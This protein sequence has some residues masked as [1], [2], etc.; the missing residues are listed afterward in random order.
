[1]ASRPPKPPDA[2]LSYTRWD[3]GRDR[4]KIS[5]FR[6]ELAAAVR[7]VTGK[8]FEIFQDVDDID[9]SERWSDKLDQMLDEARFFIPILTPSYFTSKRCREELEKFLRAEADRGR[10]D[11]VLPIYY[12]ESEI[13]EDPDLREADPLAAVIHKRQRLDWRKLRFSSFST[14]A[15]KKALES[16][17]VE[18]DRV[19]R[20]AKPPEALPVPAQAQNVAATRQAKEEARASAQRV[21][22]S[23]GD[24]P[25]HQSMLASGTTQRIA[26]DVFLSYAREDESRA[27]QLAEMLGK[28]GYAVFWD[29]RI[30]PG[31]TWHSYIGNALIAAKCVV[32]V[33]SPNSIESEFVIEEAQSGK[34]RHVLIPV[35][36]ESVQPPLGF[37]LIQAADLTDWESQGFS[38]AFRYLLNSI[39]HKVDPLRTDETASDER[40]LPQR[41]A[42]TLRVTGGNWWG[43][44]EGTKHQ[45]EDEAGKRAGEVKGSHQA[46]AHGPIKILSPTATRMRGFDRGSART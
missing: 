30:P 19:R 46:G 44:G 20:R 23:L 11:L 43:N 6:R 32:V 33:W 12:I 17:A 29:R 7:A 1:M 34:N 36:I 15:V 38:E 28:E 27:R 42:R 5:Q 45:A 41:L 25:S 24:V 3:D 39:R 14:K 22:H 10:E 2:F 18:I 21:V 4:G 16:L 40:A 37:G 9:V 31:E 13:L 26:P 8:P 35:L